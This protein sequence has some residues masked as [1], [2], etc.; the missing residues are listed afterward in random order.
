VAIPTQQHT[1]IVEPG[2]DALQ[3]HAVDKKDRQRN[4]LFS[5]VIEESIL[6]V[7]R[8]FGCHGRVPFFARVFARDIRCPQ[9]SSRLR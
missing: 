3:L 9:T 5:D 8:T 6:K 1:E 2:D 7:L 4:F